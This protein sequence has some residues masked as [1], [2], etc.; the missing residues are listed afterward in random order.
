MKRIIIRFAVLL[1]VVI[2]CDFI[3]G[4]FL[5]YITNKI[6]TGG[7]GRENY[8]CNKC[9]D[10]ILVFGSS[11]ALHHYDMPILADSLGMSGYNCGADGCG[12]LSSYAHLKMVRERHQP[13]I[14]ILDLVTGFDL[15]EGSND[16][17][18]GWLRNRYRREGIT[19]LF[20]DVDPSSKY[21]MLSSTYPYNSSF[22]KSLFVFL[23]GNTF[24][25]ANKMGYVPNQGKM[26]RGKKRIEEGNKIITYD[27]IKL[28]YMDKFF[29]L[30]EGS[31][32][33]IV[34]SPIWYECDS[35]KS[36]EAQII[37]DRCMR[38]GIPFLDFTNHPKYMYQD[39][40]FAD[41]KHMNASGAAEFTK[42]L[43]RIIK[44]R[45]QKNNIPNS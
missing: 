45:E 32:L 9:K 20:N 44:E 11:R 42:E 28:K 37:K 21:K 38:E 23:T 7:Q 25:K 8:I 35:A 12:I 5:G 30:A 26:R 19:E 2:I 36:H 6:E 29:Q 22:I 33:Y 15:L 34:Q 1:C 39:D 24:E 17:Q 3:A 43:A 16:Q 14:I 27:A 40:Y 10:D 18:L 4:H 41:G 13:K 31:H